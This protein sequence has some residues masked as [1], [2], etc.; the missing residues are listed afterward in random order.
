LIV[1]SINVFSQ[2]KKNSINDL[3]DKELP[4]FKGLLLSG[5]SISSHDLKGKVNFA[6]QAHFIK[7]VKKL[8][9]L[10]LKELSRNKDDRFIQFLTLPLK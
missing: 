5:D 1:L 4:C 6:D 3:L 10:I 8:A 7:E 9:G 2:Q